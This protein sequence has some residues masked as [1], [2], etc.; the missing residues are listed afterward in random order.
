[1]QN[2]PYELCIDE[3]LH[4]A[5][6]FSN[7]GE[8][9]SE[10]PEN[11]YTESLSNLKLGMGNYYRM[12]AIAK[13]VG[14]SFDSGYMVAAATDFKYVESALW[15][16]TSVALRAASYLLEIV[17]ENTLLAIVDNIKSDDNVTV[18]AA[19][20]HLS[21]DTLHSQSRRINSA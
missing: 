5:N 19:F 8:Y 4:Q 13:G 21:P 10:D 12:L 20:N 18:H 6:I 17:A 9:K 15:A 14:V 11:S 2:N 1:V 7:T 16:T 3:L